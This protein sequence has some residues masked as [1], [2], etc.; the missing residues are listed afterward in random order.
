M[1]ETSDERSDNAMGVVC[2]SLVPLL[3]GARM[4]LLAVIVAPLA[5]FV[6]VTKLKAVLS[7]FVVFTSK[8]LRRRPTP[9]CCH[10]GLSH[11]RLCNGFSSCLLDPTR[12][13]RGVECAEL[14]VHLR[15]AC[16]R[17]L[18]ESGDG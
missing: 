5:L 11:F 18:A 4:L 9:L 16:L 6:Q 13:T 10:N 14:G 15:Q 17:D 8:S 1:K 2:V 7:R 12:S 3:L